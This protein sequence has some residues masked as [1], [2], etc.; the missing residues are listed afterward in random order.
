M[1]HDNKLFEKK[2]KQ[3]IDQLTEQLS[4]LLPS[5]LSR[6]DF[7]KGNPADFK[8]QQRS[9]NAMI[10]GKLSLIHIS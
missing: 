8:S 3:Q 2:R 6:H 9:L 10:G 7:S 1:T 5:I 4:K